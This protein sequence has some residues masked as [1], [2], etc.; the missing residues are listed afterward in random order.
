MLAM[1]GGD[2]NTDGNDGDGAVTIG[3]I[4]SATE[5]VE[6]TPVPT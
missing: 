6:G 2:G 3:G 5:V 4:Q 1:L